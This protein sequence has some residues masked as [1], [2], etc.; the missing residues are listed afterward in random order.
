MGDVHY[1]LFVDTATFPGAGFVPD[2]GLPARWGV[3]GAC[4]PR[5]DRH[6]ALKSRV[7]CAAFS[8]PRLCSM[9]RIGSAGGISALQHL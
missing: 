6:Q 8:S 7:R 1:H 4:R 5:R 9:P 2:R 3:H